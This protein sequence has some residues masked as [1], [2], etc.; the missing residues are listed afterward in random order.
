V[1]GTTP[2]AGLFFERVLVGV[3][4]TPESL[5]AAAQAKQLCAPNGRLDLLAVA[6]TYLAAHA[7]HA[8]RVA[9]DDII[10]GASA[11]LDR[12]RRL[13]EPDETHLLPGRLITRLC[14]E[15]HRTGAT[16]VAVGARPHRRL[17]AL[18][19][20]GHDIE[21]LHDVPCSVL[22][23]RPGWGPSKPRRLVV[24]VDGSPDG[25][26]AELAATSIAHRLS[27]ELVHVV[28]LTEDDVDLDLLRTQGEDVLLD[29]DDLAHAV[30]SASREDTLVVVGRRRA[31]D[32]RWGGSVA[33]R[34]VYSARCS[35][36]VVRHQG[37]HAPRSR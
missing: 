23:A 9:E 31:H 22:I 14:Q 26:T 5:V 36:L 8:A 15:C 3:D 19:F 18:T 11:M 25:R 34:I 7:G 12:A 10:A 27:C 6:E 13:V 29:P 21:A 32:H 4:Q 28:G 30:V 35:V 2:G 33:E 1:S 16:L 17:S 37:E 24:G 20:G